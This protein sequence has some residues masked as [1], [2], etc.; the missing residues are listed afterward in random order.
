MTIR[1]SF[2]RSSVAMLATTSFLIMTAQEKKLPSPSFTGGMAMNEVV[3]SRHSSRE[4]DTTRQLSDSTLGQLLWMTTGINRPDAKPSRFGTA[5][6]HSNPT[7][8]N[9]Q[10]IRTFVF[11]KEGAWEYL[12][13]T[14]TLSL[15]K[16][17]DHRALLAGTAAFSQEFVMDAPCSI[18]FVADMTGLPEGEQARQMA[19]VDIG[20]A[21]E[22]LNLACAS[23]GIATV[24]RATMDIEGISALLGLTPLQIPVMNN[25]IGYAR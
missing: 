17:G 1:N 24:P 9:W 14:H 15:V 10:E 12:P 23:E 6:N 20:I 4:F 3:A 11:D 8:R 18:L 13:T 7:A 19:M 22:N 25:P 2:T 5:A 16:E 21:C